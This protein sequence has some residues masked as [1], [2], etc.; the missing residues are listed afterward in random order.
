MNTQSVRILESIHPEAAVQ[1]KLISCFYFLQKRMVLDGWIAPISNQYY[2]ATDLLSILSS[3][4]WQNKCWTYVQS[5]VLFFF[6]DSNILKNSFSQIKNMILLCKY[7]VIFPSDFFQC[8]LPS[9][10]EAQVPMFLHKTSWWKAGTKINVTKPN[11]ENLTMMWI[12]RNPFL[13][14]YDSS[15]TVYCCEGFH[16]FHSAL[17]CRQNGV[18]NGEKLANS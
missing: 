8:M 5:Y 6:C 17:L 14:I 3:A 13:D 12:F 1:S 11:F 16:V 2:A 9:D 10:S 18:A 7:Y 15:Y 4:S